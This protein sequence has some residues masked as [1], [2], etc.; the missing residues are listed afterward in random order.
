MRKSVTDHDGDSSYAARHLEGSLEVVEDSLK[1]D[2]GDESKEPLDMSK[3]ANTDAE[4]KFGSLGFHNASSSVG[5]VRQP[6]ASSS[7]LSPGQGRRVSTS[8]WMRR[9]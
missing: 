8:D 9:A 5:R 4:R 1:E 3:K 2:M 7:L 6:R